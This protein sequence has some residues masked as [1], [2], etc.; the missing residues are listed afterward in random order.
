MSRL[1]WELHNFFIIRRKNTDFVSLN[2]HISISFL[3]VSSW[4]SLIIFWDLIPHLMTPFLGIYFLN[5][6]SNDFLPVCFILIFHRQTFCRSLFS[7]ETF[8]PADLFV[9]RF[10]LSRLSSIRIFAVKC[11]TVRTFCRIF[12]GSMFCHDAFHVEFLQQTF[13]LELLPSVL[14]D[15]T[16]Y[17]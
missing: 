14:C 4:A 3:G 6:S 15:W 17:F 2:L 8:L 5:D 16:F 1:W 10:S 11:F 12:S 9:D 13:L 7:P